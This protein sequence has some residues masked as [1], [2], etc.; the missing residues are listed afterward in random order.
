MTYVK[1]NY[2]AEIIG[3]CARRVLRIQNI[4]KDLQR[5]KD[6]YSGFIK[7][8]SNYVGKNISTVDVNK[9]NN[10]TVMNIISFLV[11]K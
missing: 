2:S 4:F 1:R 3:T 10:E 7:Q 6:D 9:G 8:T 11:F 5:C